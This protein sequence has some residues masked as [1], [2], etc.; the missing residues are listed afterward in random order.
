MKH[1]HRTLLAF[2]TAATL[3]GFSAVPANAADPAPE[4]KTVT[5]N[6]VDHEDR[7]HGSPPPAVWALDTFTRGVTITGGPFYVLP[8][9]EDTEASVAAK[10][11]ETQ[12]EKP[13]YTLCDVVKY[14]HLKWN[15]HAVVKDNGTFVTVA[16]DTLSPN[17][18][19][20]LAGDVPGT[21]TGGFTA[22]LVA[23]AHWCTFDASDLDGKTVEG[24]DGPTTPTWVSS[25]F[26]SDETAINDDWAWTYKTCVEQWWDAADEDSSD[27][28]TEAAGDITGKPC[29][30]TPAPTTV[31]VV[32][33]AP[34]LPVTGAS[35]TTFVAAGVGLVL[36]GAGLLVGLSVFRRRRVA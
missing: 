12:K 9:T 13:E 3:L 15:Y 36:V 32:A 33:N 25:L 18:G 14:L 30:T 23:P 19:A 35:V 29:P 6:L 22:D 5:T 7:G 28:T 10:I 21:M 27:G 8:S 11:V 24:S 16:G 1:I 34:Q 20:P 17:A 31:T 26:G 2:V 4:T